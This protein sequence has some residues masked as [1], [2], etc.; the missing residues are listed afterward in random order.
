MHCWPHRKGSFGG[1]PGSTVGSGNNA[2]CRGQ[3]RPPKRRRQG[4]G[5]PVN[6]KTVVRTWTIC[7][8]PSRTT[9]TK[10]LKILPMGR[11]SLTREETCQRHLSNPPRHAQLRYSPTDATFQ[12]SQPPATCDQGHFPSIHPRH[13]TTEIRVKAR[14]MQDQRRE[15]SHALTSVA[16]RI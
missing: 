10:K 12:P 6:R 9:G 4:H 3:S 11:D 1:A 2:G 5:R 15:D 14:D 8:R 7:L 13:A 16:T